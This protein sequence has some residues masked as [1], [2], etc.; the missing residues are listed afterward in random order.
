MRFIRWEECTSRRM[1]SSKISI[2]KQW[3]NDAG[4]KFKNVD[5]EAIDELIVTMA[6]RS[7]ALDMAGLCDSEAS[8]A[9]TKIMI[10]KLLKEPTLPGYARVL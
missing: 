8:D 1:E 2:D 4:G 3:T 6:R 10:R 7:A 5:G 9:W